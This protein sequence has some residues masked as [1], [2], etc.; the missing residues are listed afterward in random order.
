[1]PAYAEFKLYKRE[2]YRLALVDTGNLVRATL[3]SKEFWDEISGDIEEEC[4]FRVGTADKDGEGLKVIGWGKE[5]KFFLD[6]I[7][8]PFKVKPIVIEGLSHAVNLGLEFLQQTSADI[9]FDKSRVKLCFGEGKRERYTCLVAASQ[10]PFPFRG[11]GKRENQGEE[12]SRVLGM[13]WR[14]D[15][16]PSLVPQ[17]RNREV[18]IVYNVEKTSIPPCQSMHWRRGDRNPYIHC[19][20]RITRRQDMSSSRRDQNCCISV[21]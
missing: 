21:Q 13:V 2:I 3:V 12:F 1:M 10:T 4:D 11:S 6:G 16:R 14:R 5:F 9:N 8:E 18:H 20:R 17:N 19:D 15:T 7:Q